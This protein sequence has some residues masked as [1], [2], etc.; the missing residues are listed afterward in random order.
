MRWRPRNLGQRMAGPAALL[1]QMAL[2]FAEA[3]VTGLTFASLWACSVDSRRF[4]QTE[5]E[6]LLDGT[7]PT[8]SFD[9]GDGIPTSDRGDGASSGTG[10]AGSGSEAA[11]ASQ[12]SCDGICVDSLVDP[13]NC[14]ECGHSCL[15]MFGCTSG[16]CDSDVLEVSAGALSSC[17]VLRNGQSHCWGQNQFGQLGD[18]TLAGTDLCAPDIRCR[19]R[20]APV[21][22]ETGDPLDDIVHVANAFWHACAVRRDGS[23]FCWGRNERGQLGHAGNDLTCTD[24]DTTLS[25]NPTS[26]RAGLPAGVQ[27]SEIGVGLRYSCGRTPAGQVYCWGD[28]NVG[29]LALD[30]ATVA[31]TA[32]PT[33]I[34]NLPQP[35]MQLSLANQGDSACALLMDGSVWCWGRNTGGGLGHPAA[36]DAMCGTVSC[37]FVPMMV[38]D[39]QGQPFVAESIAVGRFAACALRAGSVY[40]WGSNATGL[41]GTGSGDAVEHSTPQVLPGLPTIVGL[42]LTD[43]TAFAL[44]SNGALWGWGRNNLGTVGDGTIIGNGCTQA[45]RATPVQLTIESISSVSVTATVLALDASGAVWGWGGNGSA[46]LGHLPGAVADLACGQGASPAACSPTAAPIDW[47]P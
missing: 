46:Q 21:V 17:I 38:L 37:S 12:T 32:I 5:Q 16:Q 20:A 45:C 22:Q 10:D 34:Q 8:G 27:I 35:V 42:S 4:E 23:V 43:L 6:A 30:P 28:N 33:R 36:M 19:P 47:A 39:D 29:Q 26:R 44:D 7:N 25:C 24:G 11:C 2:P 3:T 18:G 31:S 9:G 13:A 15:G 40:C 1:A 41:L 14:G